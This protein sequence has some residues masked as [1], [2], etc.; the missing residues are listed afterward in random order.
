ML[1]C[2][3]IRH[4]VQGWQNDGSIGTSGAGRGDDRERMHSSEER[5]LCACLS[6]VGGGS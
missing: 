6:G 2:E 1:C 3:L 4:M 5:N